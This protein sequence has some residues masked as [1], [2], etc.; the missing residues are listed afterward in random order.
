MKARLMATSSA[1]LFAAMAL[2]ATNLG[3]IRV[4]PAE[5]DAMQAHDAAAP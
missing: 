1:L 4:T 5:V 2:G 3:Q